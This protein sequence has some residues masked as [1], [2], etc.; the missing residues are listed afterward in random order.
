MDSNKLT[1]KESQNIFD[2]F[3]YEWFDIIDE[4]RVVLH[5]SYELWKE[6]IL[7]K[8]LGVICILSTDITSQDIY[9][10]TDEKKWFINKIKYGF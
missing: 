4:Y 9:I 8:D 10:I 1:Q 7:S 5:E 2:T 6:F 3:E